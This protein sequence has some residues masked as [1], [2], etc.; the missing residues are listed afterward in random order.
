MATRNEAPALM[1]IHPGSIL[2]EELIER[3]ISQKDFASMI[4]M[5]PSHLSEIIK[6]KR[7]ITKQ[8]ADKLEEV[9]G[10][11]SIDWVNLQIGFDYKTQQNAERKIA[12]T[13]AY[14]V[15]QEYSKF[16][17]VKILEQRLGCV[18]AF[19]TETVEFLTTI[20]KLPEPKRL[21]LQTQGLFKKSGK[22][23]KDPIKIMTWLLLAKQYAYSKRLDKIFDETRLNE[24]VPKIAS[25]LHENENTIERLEDTFAQYGILFGIVPKV[26]GAS[27]D[28]YSFEFEGHPCIIVTKR[29][30]KIDNF[31]FSVMHELGHVINH[32]YEDFNVDIEDYDHE[33]PREKAA[34]QFAA[35]ALIS[36]ADWKTVPKV[37]L[38]PSVI[39]KTC[40]VWAEMRG[41]NKWIALGRLSYQTG[42]YKFKTDAT[43]SI[44]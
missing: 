22:V 37:R 20:F 26:E 13:A 27:I 16:F 23:G 25:I 43:R 14:N 40:S 42:M 41:Y 8:V 10:I 44:S 31:A 17:N 9:L 36:D 24:L 21:Q 5:Q 38:S 6:G 3:G 28:G 12:E 35:N 33:S 2:K 1:A 4:A 34:N 19:C 18:H 11:P 7:S 32:D 39:Q 15:I 29:Y 30:D